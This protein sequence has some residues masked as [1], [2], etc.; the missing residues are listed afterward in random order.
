M[1]RPW[2]TQTLTWSSGRPM[3]FTELAEERFK[4]KNQA[5]VLVEIHAD[6]QIDVA[7]A[8]TEG[9]DLWKFFPTILVEDIGGIR[10]NTTGEGARIMSYGLTGPQRQHEQADVAAGNDN[11]IELVLYLPFSKPHAYDPSDF[12]IPVELLKRIVLGGATADTLDIG[13]SAVGIDSGTVFLRTWTRDVDAVFMGARDVI[14]EHAW[15][16]T[17][18]TKLA[19][20]GGYLC[21]AYA[22]ASGASG[23]AAMTNFVN[24]RIDGIIDNN[25]ERDP[26]AISHY[27]YNRLLGD[28][29]S[30]T[31]GGELYLDP[32]T[33]GRAAPLY[34]PRAGAKI[35]DHP[36]V[37]RSAKVRATNTVSSPIALYRYIEPKSEKE[38]TFLMTKYGLGK[39]DFRA[40]TSKRSR[41]SPSA[42]EGMASFLPAR[43]PDPAM[44]G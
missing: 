26:D 5:V 28:T 22:Y 15:D 1:Y 18:E 16:T 21:E 27:R 25:W 8:T 33:A 43:A 3:E 7:T 42:W 19:V 9:E 2:D 41:R 34:I 17:N 23:G 44:A 29:A 37:R 35:F 30:G 11:A 32:V 20:N 13:S 38:A 4:G 40:H 31:T 24:H 10:W 36:F 6:I 39:Q 14:V 12:E